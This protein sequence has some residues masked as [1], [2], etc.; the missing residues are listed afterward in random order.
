MSEIWVCFGFCVGLGVR[1]VSVEHRQKSE[2]VTSEAYHNPINQVVE[3][4]SL[5]WVLCRFGGARCQ[6]RKPTKQNKK[7]TSETYTTLENGFW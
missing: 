6:L 4:M 7:L 5:C 3:N 1:D 2:K